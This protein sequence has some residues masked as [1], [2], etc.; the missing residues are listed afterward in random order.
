MMARTD[1][2]GRSGRAG[3]LQRRSLLKLGAYAAA[4]LLPMPALARTAPGSAERT[5]KLYNLHTGEQLKATFWA[6]G[7]YLPDAQAEIDRILRDHYSDEVTQIDPA[8]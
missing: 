4:L 2:A 7:R 3:R 1:E 8:L 5:L 6:A